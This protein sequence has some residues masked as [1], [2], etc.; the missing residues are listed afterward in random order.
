[1][2]LC[3][4]YLRR[5]RGETIDAT[6]KAR[7]AVEAASGEKATNIVML[8]TR[9]VC[10]FTD[11]FV[12][13]S[14]ES[15]PQVNAILDEV[16]ELLGKNKIKCLH[17]EGDA[18]SGWVLLDYGDVIVHVFSESQREHYQLDQLWSNAVQVVRIQ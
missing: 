13:C 18:D 2:T 4:N 11:Y 5:L 1:M 8:D 3:Y 16:D 14:A 15:E 12:I 10:H 9:Q 17:R 7:L 6:E